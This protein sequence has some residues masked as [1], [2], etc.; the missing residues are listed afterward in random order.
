[1]VAFDISGNAKH[2][3]FSHFDYLPGVLPDAAV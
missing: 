2:A 1:M 3:D